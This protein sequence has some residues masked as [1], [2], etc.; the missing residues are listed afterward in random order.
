MEY[1]KIYKGLEKYNQSE[2]KVYCTYL[3]ELVGNSKTAGW[4]SKIS[5]NQA[6]ALY[7]KVALDNLFIDGDTITLSFRGKVLI[8]YNYQA[9]K[10]KL[11]NIYPESKFDVQLVH[12]GDTFKFEKK[13]GK[14]DYVHNINDPFGTSKTTIGCYCIIKNSRGEFI[15]TLNMEDITK[16]RN[17]AK[18][19]AIWNAWEGEMILKSVI[20]RACKRHFKDLIVNI[21]K[22]D[23]TNYEPETVNIDFKLKD[24]IEKCDTLEDLNIIYTENKDNPGDEKVFMEL[25]GQRKLEIKKKMSEETPTE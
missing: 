2:V 19:Q 7:E 16:M 24:A 4:A 17:V 11:L 10:N 5:E 12:D 1:K 9:Y 13:S 25:L 21:D 14:V 6:I 15:E 22:I 18:T 20:K 8:S 3:S 23:N